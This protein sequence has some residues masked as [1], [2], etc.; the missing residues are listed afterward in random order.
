MIP[1]FLIHGVILEN[2]NVLEAAFRRLAILRLDIERVG[3]TRIHRDVE[4]KIVGAGIWR[5]IAA[6]FGLGKWFKLNFN[7]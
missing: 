2:N 6:E 3:A 7:G 4:L 1:L 5:Y